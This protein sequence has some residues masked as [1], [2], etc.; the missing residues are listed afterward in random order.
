VNDHPDF[1]ASS[2][3]L[4]AIGMPDADVKFIHAFYPPAVCANYF[5]ALHDETPWR[6]EQSVIWGKEVV[7]PRLTAWYGDADTDYSYSGISL[8]PIPWTETL[9]HIKRDIEAITGHSFNAV[10]LNLYRDEQDGVGWHSDDERVFGKYP[11]IASLS[12][13]ETRTFKFRHKTRPELKTLAL[14]LTNGS[15]LVMAGKTQACWQH[16][17]DKVRAKKDP[18]INMT[19][20]RILK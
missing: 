17:I 5:A 18:R 11:V 10:L 7:H 6:Q 9:L 12:L 13:G 15:L 2:N 19:F 8:V 3:Q 1:F 14:E 4:E 20:R 16:S